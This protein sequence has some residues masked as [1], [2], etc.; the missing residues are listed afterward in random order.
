MPREALHSGQFCGMALVTIATVLGQYGAGYAGCSIATPWLWWRLRLT[1]LRLP[2][3]MGAGDH[4]GQD[5]QPR[6]RGLPLRVGVL[7]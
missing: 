3:Q 6:L 2:L 4:A 1:R 5:A 7:R